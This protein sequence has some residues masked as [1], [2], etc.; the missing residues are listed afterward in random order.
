MNLIGMNVDLCDTVVNA[1]GSQAGEITTQLSTVTS[2]VDGLLTTWQGNSRTTFENEWTPWVSKV[3]TL[4]E[5][6]Q[7]VQQRLKVTVDNFRSA[8]CF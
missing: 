2:A 8:D 7:S 6:M 4:I 1:F 5:A 3:Q